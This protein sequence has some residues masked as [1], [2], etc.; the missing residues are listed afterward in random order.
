MYLY[1]QLIDD[2]AEKTLFSL[3]TKGVKGKND[4]ERAEILGKE[5]AEK[6]KAKDINAIV[7]DRGGFRYTGKV[8]ALADG[9]RNGG[10]IF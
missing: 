5:L 10:L 3:S 1:A 2:T 4:L 7:F 9:V 6:A 8:K